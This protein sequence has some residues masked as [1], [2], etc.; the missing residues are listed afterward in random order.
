MKFNE[1]YEKIMAE[2]KKVDGAK[3]EWAKHLRPEGK[4]KANKQA[5]KASKMRLQK[6]DEAS[7]NQ[8]RKLARGGK[9]DKMS[10]DDLIDT[11]SYYAGIEDGDPNNEDARLN[12][13]KKLEKEMEK[14]GFYS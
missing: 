14:R 12:M 1:L 11:Y 13:V 10:D 2:S 4:R 5:R 3:S 7:I 9:F 8:L 6:M